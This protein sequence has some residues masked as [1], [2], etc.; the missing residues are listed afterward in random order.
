M[1]VNAVMQYLFEKYGDRERKKDGG[2][3]GREEIENSHGCG[4]E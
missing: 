1:F 3:G 2:A 4:L